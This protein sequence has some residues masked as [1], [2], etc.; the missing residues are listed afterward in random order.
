M[1]NNSDK[2]ITSKEFMH[3]LWR[4]KRGSI[5]RREFLGVT[6]LGMATAVM[7]AA[8]PSLIPQKSWA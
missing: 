6:G 3:Q 5:T 2:K 1:S 7:G 8:M 4:Y